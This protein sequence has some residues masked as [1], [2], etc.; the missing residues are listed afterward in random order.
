MGNVNLKD[1]NESMKFCQDILNKKIKMD[2]K[3]REQYISYDEKGN[4]YNKTGFEFILANS[5]DNPLKYSKSIERVTYDDLKNVSDE[6]IANYVISIYNHNFYINVTGDM[7]DGL[8]SYIL[9]SYNLTDFI[10]ISVILDYAAKRI[11]VNNKHFISQELEDIIDG[12]INP[13]SE[14]KRNIC[15][16][17]KFTREGSIKKLI[18]N[19]YVIFLKE[20]FPSKLDI[21]E[22]DSSNR[23]LSYI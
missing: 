19:A 3:Y 2:Y 17:I 16:F 12:K 15:L 8:S 13:G 4:K 21:L 9:Q 10:G 20:V 1:R 6:V 18:A 7:K 5:I 11:K 23:K 14:Q 22:S